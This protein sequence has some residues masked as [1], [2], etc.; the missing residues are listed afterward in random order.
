MRILH[1][2]DTHLFADPDARHYD[3]IDTDAAL[4][5]VLE[6]LSHLEG[7]DL[8]LHTG[9]AS[10]DGTP[11][12]YG[13][14]HEHLDPFARSLGA[15]LAVA[16]G[17]HDVPDSY[18]TIAGEG[19]HGDSWQDR[20]SEL[21]GGWR[22]VVLDSSVPGAGYGRLDPEQLEWLAGILAEPAPRGT[23]LAIHHPP[24]TAA[25]PLLRALDLIGADELAGVLAGTDVRLVLAGHYHHPMTGA[26][27]GIP[28]HVAPGITNVMDPLA[29]AGHEQAGA[30]SG[31]S[32]IDLDDEDPSA[33]PVVTTSVWA[34]AG[35]VLGEPGR[36]V[37]D[38][39]ADAVRAVIAASGPGS[40]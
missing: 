13:R 38:L 26:V 4:A 20:M 28:V 35:D 10:E 22:L 9:D 17:N 39:D 11:A 31:A 40:R 16:M 29:P 25:T 19:D 23:V 12:S 6:R 1:L 8:V 24:L 3:R 34:N 15:E 27:A 36:P 14:L 37:Y 33:P 32:V 30:L 2:S 21:P 18:A 5:R 7:V